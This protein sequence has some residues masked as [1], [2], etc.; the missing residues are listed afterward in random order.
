VKAATQTSTVFD[1]DHY[2]RLIEARGQTI[3]QS[4][5]SLKHV[6]GLATALDA[7]CGLGFFAQILHESGLAVRAFDGREE[8]IQEGRRRFPDIG[9]ERGDIQDSKIRG[10]GEFDFVLCFGL[11]YHLENPLAAIRNLR[12]LTSKALLLESMC[13]PEL[14]PW[15]LLREEPRLEDQ[16]LTDVAFYASEGCLAKMLYRAGF[17]FVYRADVL[18]DHDDFK[19]TPE[20]LR[21]RTVLLATAAELATPGFTLFPEPKELADPWQLEAGRVSTFRRRVSSFS[22]KSGQEKYLA[23]AQRAKRFIP[24]LPIP[25]RLSFGAWWLV[26]HGA[27]DYDVMTNRFETAE[28]E[29]VRRFLGPGMTVLDIGA[30]HGLY[31]LLASKSVGTQGKVISFEPSPRERRRLQKHLRLNRVRNVQLHPF[32]LGSQKGEAD[33]YLA[34]GTNNGCNSFRQPVESDGQTVRVPVHRLDDVLSQSKLARVDFVKIDVEG[35][36]LDTFKGATELFS[37]VP[38]PVVMAETFDI[39]TRPWGY[40]A[41][42]IVRFLADLNYQWFR[43]NDDGTLEA[44]PSNLQ[45]YDANLVAFPAE[46]VIEVQTKLSAV[47]K[48]A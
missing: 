34:D 25:M 8:N 18:P 43:L 45:T 17:P 26:E 12:A 29:F 5:A 32:A 7:G 4:I 30:H 13:L 15:M 33:L 38:R 10:L 23:L 37:R 28:I 42:E 27:V 11:L 3:R 16:S 44:I 46:R 39:R 1:H 14:T 47:P 31:T 19:D 2:L 6:L 24:A 22:K 35:A 20:H 36:E 21:R 48:Q 40:D 41:R 9:F